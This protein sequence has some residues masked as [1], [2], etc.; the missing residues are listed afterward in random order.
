MH[1]LPRLDTL[2]VVMGM[3]KEPRRGSS[4]VPSASSEREA[5]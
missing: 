2:R 1:L 5:A 4:A 3:R